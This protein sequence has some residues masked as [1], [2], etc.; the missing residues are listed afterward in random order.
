[1]VTTLDAD[2]DPL[3]LADR[4]SPGSSSLLVGGWASTRL[5][6]APVERLHVPGTDSE[7]VRPSCRRTSATAPTA[8]STVVFRVPR[9]VRPGD[10]AR[11]CRRV[12][13]RAARAVPTGRGTPLLVAGPHGLYGTVI[14]TLKLADGEGLHRRSAA[15]RSVTR[16]EPSVVRHRRAGDPARPRPDLLAGPAEG[17]VDRAADRADR[18]AR[19]SSASRGR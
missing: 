16:R 18:A 1:M 14:S 11:A 13:D 4:S 2:G 10:A 19:S 12:V 8:R 3:P 6:V 5:S 9:R 7:H 17:R 15:R